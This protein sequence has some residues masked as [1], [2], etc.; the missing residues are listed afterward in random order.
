MR[1]SVMRRSE[2]GS[3]ARSHQRGRHPMA[4]AWQGQSL[5]VPN[6]PPVKRRCY[7]RSLKARWLSAMLHQQPRCDA[8]TDRPVWRSARASVCRQLNLVAAQVRPRPQR[9]RP[10]R[11]PRDTR[12]LLARLARTVL[13]DKIAAACRH[14]P[15]SNQRL[16]RSCARAARAD[17]ANEHYGPVTAVRWMLLRAHRTRERLSRQRSR[18][19]LRWHW[20]SS[21][22]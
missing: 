18:L 6:E 8:S 11:D 14:G 5:N 9:S 3:G 13:R 12:K 17:S 4:P 7:G 19:C 21:A 16:V 20:R 15:I 22:C 1:V 10:G 2:E